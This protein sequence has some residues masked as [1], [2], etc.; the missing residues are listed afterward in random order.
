M[1]RKLLRRTGC[2]GGPGTGLYDVASRN[3]A[4]SRPGAALQ[5]GA[6]GHEAKISGDDI[7][8]VTDAATAAEETIEVRVGLSCISADQ[9]RRS[10]EREMP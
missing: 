2:A 3:P 4:C 8:Y 6:F 1:R 9:A 7:G 10:L 5:N